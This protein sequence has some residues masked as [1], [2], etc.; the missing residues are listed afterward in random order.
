MLS[1]ENKNKSIMG[2]TEA[3]LHE[4]VEHRKSEN[5]EE[6]PLNQILKLLKK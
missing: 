2:L 6:I 1:K 3:Q 4:I 5:K